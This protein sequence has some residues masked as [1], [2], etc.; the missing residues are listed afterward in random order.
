[1]SDYYCKNAPL[2]PI[3]A[4]YH[5]NEYGFPEKDES[6]LFERLSLEIMQAGLSWET[7]LKKRKSLN[8]AFCDFNAE[9]VASFTEKDME[10]LL[11]DASIIRNRLKIQSIIHNA[12]VILEFRDSH[13]GFYNWLIYNNKES[14]ND[15]VKLFK[16]TFKFTGKEIVSEFLMSIGIIEGAHEDW[17]PVKNLIKVKNS[18]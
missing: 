14:I 5:A 16:K 4:Y 18:A 3:H 1:M 12:S 17:C 6:R 10:R 8:S 15:W 11:N 13:N 2:S 9:K 7:V